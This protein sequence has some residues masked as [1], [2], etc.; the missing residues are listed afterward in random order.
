[1]KLYFEC[2]VELCISNNKKYLFWL[3]FRHTLTKFINV[4]PSVYI[5]HTVMI[6]FNH[7]LRVK[8]PRIQYCAGSFELAGLLG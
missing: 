1:M 5:M 7:Y 2:S 4:L 6:V 8:D 3:D